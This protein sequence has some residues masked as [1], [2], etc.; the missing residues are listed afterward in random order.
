ML[1]FRIR[2]VANSFRS[3]GKVLPGNATRIV[4]A[5]KFVE[6]TE[7]QRVVVIELFVVTIVLGDIDSC[8]DLC[9]ISIQ[10]E[11]MIICNHNA[12][13]T[14]NDERRKVDDGTECAKGNGQERELHVSQLVA[15]VFQVGS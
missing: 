13:L 10:H 7:G 3:R 5:K 2:G 4:G 14:V 8:K 9:D 6:V 12:S 15:A 1:I 11:R